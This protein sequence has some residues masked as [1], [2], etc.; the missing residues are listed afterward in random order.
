MVRSNTNMR[1]SNHDWVCGATLPSYTVLD[2]FFHNARPKRKELY[3]HINRSRSVALN[4]QRGSTSSGFTCN[5]PRCE[6]RVLRV[7]GTFRV[8]LLNGE[9]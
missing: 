1:T 8:A 2:T 7:G 6:R 5:D 9:R 3:Y 4:T